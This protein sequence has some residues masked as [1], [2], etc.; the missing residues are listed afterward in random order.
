MTHNKP[1]PKYILINKSCPHISQYSLYKQ[2]RNIEREFEKQM[3]IKFGKKSKNTTRRKM[4]HDGNCKDTYRK[5]LMV[6]N[7]IVGVFTAF[8]GLN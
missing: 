2:A 6:I 8:M 1:I 3:A 7:I 4:G 5:V